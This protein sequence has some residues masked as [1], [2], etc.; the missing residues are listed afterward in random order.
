MFD[1]PNTINCPECDGTGAYAPSCWLCEG[2]RDVKIERAIAEGYD[3]DDLEVYD[4]GYCR[5]PAYECRGDSC[6]LCEGD[7][8]VDPR[9]PEDEITRV[10]VFGLADFIPPRRYR[11][12]NG[13]TVDHDELL[14]RFAAA[15]CRERGWLH[16]FVSVF[17][18]ELS[19][20][21]EG[22]AEAGRRYPDW[23]K[24]RDVHHA[25]I[26]ALGRWADDGGPE[27]AR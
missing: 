14:A 13:R 15:E 7:G 8:K 16:W 23:V 10:L 5:C 27:V 19:L 9:V 25:P 26:D 18:D 6:D 11:L 12:H 3:I 17:G 20:T 21:P 22:E 24:G 1:N 4:D 2:T